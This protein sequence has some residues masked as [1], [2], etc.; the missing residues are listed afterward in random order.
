VINAAGHLSMLG[1][2]VSP[3]GLADVV[4]DAIRAGM[5]QPVDMA[6][7]KDEASRRIAEATAAEAGCVT[8]G[9]AAGIAL[10]VA[11][12]VAGAH[13]E[14]VQAV[15]FGI[16]R[17]V[18]LQAGHDID[19]GAPVLQMVALGGGVPRLAG[20]HKEITENDL[21]AGLSGAAAFLFVQS[22]HV[23]VPGRLP[24]A[25]CIRLAHAASVPVI[26]DAAA[27][28]DLRAYVAAGAD[29]V[30]Y[31][32]GKALGGLS[33]SGMVAGRADLIAAVRAQERGIGRAMKVGPE[34]LLSVCLS[35][36]LYRPG[37]DSAEVLRRLEAGCSRLAGATFRVIDDEA[38]RPI[39][40]LEVATPRAREVVQALR[41]NDPPV[42][43]RA[44]QVEA[45]CFAID[46]RNLTLE[47]AGL[48]VQA[49]KVALA[50]P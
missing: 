30:I 20:S 5:T 37:N 12:C 19:F 7:L 35:L 45:G 14:A 43:V 42:Y 48:V 28:E 46:P 47:E 38:G 32:G 24:L 25:T 22:H 9:A 49:L 6:W 26:V 8:T 15:P 16:P 34:Q 29:L 40:R 36:E 2:G 1:G 44:H 13:L 18:V 17:P 39:R 33:S 23:H 41:R 3:E 21:A 10:S 50:R 11:A 4:S 31:S 27:E